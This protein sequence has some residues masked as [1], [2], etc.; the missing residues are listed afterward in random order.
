LGAL[1]RVFTEQQRERLRVY[2]NRTETH[3][4]NMKISH[5]SLCAVALGL[6][7]LASRA[8]VDVGINIGVPAPVVVV[9]QPPAPRVEVVTTAPGPDYFWIAGRW[10]W[11]G[12]RWVWLNGHYERHPHFH[13][14]GGWEQG[15]WEHR[16]GNSVWVEGRWR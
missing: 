15:H 1:G 2:G 12:G 6:A 16:G 7:P 10:N 8:G 4:N 13:P 9:G 11:D 5:I 3:K 14:G